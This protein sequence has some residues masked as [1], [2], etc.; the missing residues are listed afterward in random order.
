ML[1]VY[2]LGIVASVQD[3]ELR[4]KRSKRF[5]VCDS[6]C[7]HDLAIKPLAAVA[8]W[9]AILVPMDAIAH[10]EGRTSS[11]M[12]VSSDQYRSTPTSKRSAFPM[13]CSLR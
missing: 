3:R 7:P 13:I 10:R 2:A 6:V 9:I 11:I 8:I 12:R 1:W 5:F 4:I